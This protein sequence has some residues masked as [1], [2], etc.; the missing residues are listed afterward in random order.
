MI[1]HRI[2][3]AISKNIIDNE[4]KTKILQIIKELLKKKSNCYDA[5]FDIFKYIGNDIKN[6]YSTVAPFIF[7]Y[8]SDNQCCSL[9]WK[10]DKYIDIDGKTIIVPSRC[11]RNRI[12]NS[13]LYCRTHNNPKSSE[14]CKLCSKSMEQFIYHAKNWEHFGNIFQFGLN[15]C[16]ND[17]H[18]ENCYRQNYSK[19]ADNL[20][21]ISYAD[22]IMEQNKNKWISYQK[23]T[24]IKLDIPNLKFTTMQKLEKDIIVLK[25]KTKNTAELFEQLKLPVVKNS[26]IYINLDDELRSILWCLLLN[27]IFNKNPK[28]EKSISPI[29]IFDKENVSL[30]TN[31]KFIY[32]TNFK[33]EG[34]LLNNDIAVFKD[35]IQNYV[36]SIDISKLDEKLLKVFIKELLQ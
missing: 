30:Y 26:S 10:V 3:E 24:I 32:N 13:S 31:D 7:I 4:N 27:H 14:F 2:L 35:D 28:I 1:T 9:I 8:Y 18:I 19:T 12:D 16:F 25:K 5:F 15:P 20:K 6:L 23:E 33:I 34:I 36:N 11:S 29:T 17:K 22:F 21:C